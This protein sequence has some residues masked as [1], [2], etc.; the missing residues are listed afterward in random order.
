[1][2]SDQIYDPVLHN[3]LELRFLQTEGPSFSVCNYRPL[4]PL[5]V[6]DT[7]ARTA[8]PAWTLKILPSAEVYQDSGQTINTAGAAVSRAGA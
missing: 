4:W 1:M 2:P 7:V 8:P 3:N 6:Y 5:T